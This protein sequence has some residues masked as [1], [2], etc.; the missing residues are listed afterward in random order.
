[1]KYLLDTDICIFFLQGKYNIIDK[2]KAVGLENCCISEITIAELK[3]GA[4]KSTNKA[5]H[6]E[7]VRKI[8]ELFTVVPVYE[9]FDEYAKEKVRL[10]KEGSLIPDF[11]L[12]IATTARTH[13]LKLVTNNT[14]HLARVEGTTIVNWVE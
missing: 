11:D 13:Q 9:A 14:K 7:E 12:L 5:K 10:Q 1:M 3:Y 6:L 2:I 8:E 4:E